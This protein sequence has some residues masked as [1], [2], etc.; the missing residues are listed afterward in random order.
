MGAVFQPILSTTTEPGHTPFGGSPNPAFDLTQ[1]LAL[2]KEEE[3]YYPG[4]QHNTK[5]MFTRLRKIFYDQWGWNSELIRG[6]TKIETRYIASVAY[7]ATENTRPMGT[8]SQNP[9]APG[10][11]RTVTYS[12]TDRVYGNTRV[13]QTP[14]IYK[15]DHQEVLLPE[16]FYCDVAHIL[17]GVD[18]FNYKQVVSPLPDWL[19]FLA[20][21]LPHVDSNV[22]LVTW[23]GDIASSAGDFL[24]AYLRNNNKP[25]GP[26]AEQKYINI[27]APG[28]DMLGDI[29]ALVIA[30]SYDVGTSKGMRVTE[31]YED[32]YIGKNGK[33]PIKDQRFEIFCKIVGLNWDGKEF[34]NKADWIAY[35]RRELKAQTE[36]Q[37]FSLT[38][39]KLDGIWLPLKVYFGYY[40]EV[41]KMDPLLELFLDTLKTVMTKN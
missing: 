8:M 15:N 13:G 9:E 34:T 10:K 32:Y 22:D 31:I 11:H 19:F 1:F 38:D 35:Q 30:N 21:L 14:E 29:D 36:F 5:L 12:A 18:A 41:I 2:L 24:F 40:K 6:A 17:A 20:K 37:I 4:E 28:S 26:E 3:D 25:I 16:G 23:L 33:T 27:D 7:A 39:E